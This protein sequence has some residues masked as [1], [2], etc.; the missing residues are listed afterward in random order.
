MTIA[1]LVQH[2]ILYYHKGLDSTS[3]PLHLDWDLVCINV[4][5][6]ASAGEHSGGYFTMTLQLA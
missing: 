2:A 4:M 5:P 6:I 1:E 3:D